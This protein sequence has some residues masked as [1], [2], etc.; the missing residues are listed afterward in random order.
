MT[1]PAEPVGGWRACSNPACLRKVGG[2]AAYCCGGCDAAH[3]YAFDAEGYH[4]ESCEAR[5]EA[6]GVF[7][8]A[9]RPSR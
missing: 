2:S 9:T 3:R 7:T 1:D 5:A 8:V 4:T 6:R